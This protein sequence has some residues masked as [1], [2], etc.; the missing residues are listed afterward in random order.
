MTTTEN[1]KNDL[2]VPAAASRLNA[3]VWLVRR[4]CD[5]VLSPCR[6]VGQYRSISQADLEKLRAALRERARALKTRRPAWRRA[7]A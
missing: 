5:E 4:L 3:P 1:E 2:T 6:R 7:V